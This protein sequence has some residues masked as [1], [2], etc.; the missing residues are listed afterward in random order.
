MPTPVRVDCRR[1]IEDGG[2]TFVTV[3]RTTVATVM[4][5]DFGELGLDFNGSVSQ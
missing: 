5:E 3:I 4:A 1:E 2:E